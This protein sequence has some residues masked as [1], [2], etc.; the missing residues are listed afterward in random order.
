MNV[1]YTGVFLDSPIIGELN[2]VIKYQ[3]VTH[4]FRP[5]ASEINPSFFGKK[6]LIS[7]TG[8]A[9]NGTNEGY[10]V[11][12]S[13]GDENLLAELKKIKTPHITASVSDS[14]K[15][16]DTA[17]LDFRPFHGEIIGTYGAFCS[18]GRVHFSL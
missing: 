6:V 2:N 7:I 10:L 5:D 8:Y 4:Q 1:I 18:D 9:N 3:H 15:P 14:G 16:V 17:K 13:C 11:Y 12:L